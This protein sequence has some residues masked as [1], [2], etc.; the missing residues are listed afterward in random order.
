MYR[1]TPSQHYKYT[2][3]IPHRCPP[4]GFRGAE[5]SEKLQRNDDNSTSDNFPA[6]THIT[7]NCPPPGLHRF[8]LQRS[9]VQLHQHFSIT[10]SIL[11]LQ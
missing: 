9:N 5:G 8:Y 7:T 11:Q 4:T 1:Y 10:S 3:R 6:R 2:P